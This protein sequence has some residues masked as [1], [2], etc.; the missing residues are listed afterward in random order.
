MLPLAGE[1]NWLFWGCW[2][3]LP[4]GRT[5]PKKFRHHDDSTPS[6]T[7]AAGRL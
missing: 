5:L 7:L 1:A 4:G 3:L 2:L 6:E